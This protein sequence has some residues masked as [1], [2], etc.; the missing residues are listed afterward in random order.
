M[1][2][3]G[4]QNSSSLFPWRRFWISCPC[5]QSNHKSLTWKSIMKV[6]LFFGGVGAEDSAGTLEAL[7]L[8]QWSRF[9]TDR[10]SGM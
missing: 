5:S 1:R 2:E 6:V 4:V 9:G 7:H 8:S 10:S 3:N